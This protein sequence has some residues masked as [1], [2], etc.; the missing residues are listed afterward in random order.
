[1]PARTKQLT[2]EQREAMDRKLR[3]GVMQKTIAREFGV[4]ESFV[5]AFKRGELKH[6]PRPA[7]AK[8]QLCV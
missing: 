6:C 5:A 8:V 7:G 4:S 3:L 2:S 1:M